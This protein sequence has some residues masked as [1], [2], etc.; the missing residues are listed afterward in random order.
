V[1]NKIVNNLGAINPVYFYGSIGTGKTHLIQAIGN[2]LKKNFSFLKIKYIN[3]NDFVGEYTKAL[4][5]KKDRQFRLKYRLLDVLLLDDIQFL[6]GKEQSCVEFFDIFNAIF[7]AEKQMIFVSDRLPSELDNIQERLK[8]RL[9]SSMIIELEK[10]NF[11]SK[12]EI[13]KF[14]LNEY[15]LKIEED[16]C[17]YIINRIGP[18]IRKILGMVNTI[19]T[20]KDIYNVKIDLNFCHKYLKTLNIN[21]NESNLSEENILIS[22]SNYSKI[23][24]SEIKSTKRTKTISFY[25][26]VVMYLLRKYTTLSLPEI[27]NYLGGKTSAAVHSGINNIQ[28]ELKLNNSL[29]EKIEK[30]VISN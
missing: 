22:V 21:L 15:N 17:E 10:P 16:I 26:H 28:R 6:M 20:Y 3:P 13:F 8:S 4:V 29:I 30:I 11:Q 18:D 23:S 19:V 9:N 25:R 14:Y 2:Y 7:Q 12:M 27:G 1:A 24:V 5:L